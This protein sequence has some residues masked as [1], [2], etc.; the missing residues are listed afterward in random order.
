MCD[1]D[2]AG[3]FHVPHLTELIFPAHK[4]VFSR[5]N[6]VEALKREICF[7]ALEIAGH[8]HDYWGSSSVSSQS[9]RQRVSPSASV[10][11]D[12]GLVRRERIADTPRGF[13]GGARAGGVKRLCQPRF[14]N[15]VASVSLRTING[16][17]SRSSGI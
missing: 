12:A 9:V 5:E 8:F 15:S 17:A 11:Q 4:I 2:R 1:Y 6:R 13:E 10:R 7:R 3:Y 14:R 16:E